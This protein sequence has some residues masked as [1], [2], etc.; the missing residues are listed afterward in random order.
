MTSVFL[1]SRRGEP[2]VI[3]TNLE[4]IPMEIAGFKAT[5]DS[6]PESVY[7][8]LNADKHVYRH[9]RSDDGRQVDLYIG[10][11]GTAKGGRTPHNPFGCL[12]GAG[13]GIVKSHKVQLTAHRS[14]LTKYYPHGVEVNYILSQKGT[15]YD[16]VLHWY[17][18]DRKKI[19]S[20]GIQSNIQRFLGRTFYNRND[21]AFIRVSVTSDQSHINEAKKLAKFFAEKILALIPNYWP[22][23]G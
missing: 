8:E 1:I 16:V 21:G 15:I 9:Y 10:Y 7:K 19:L 13:W 22:I 14:P 23:E 11:Y 12:P 18:S 20:T 17:Q 4:N 3:A 5:E 6:F 2:V